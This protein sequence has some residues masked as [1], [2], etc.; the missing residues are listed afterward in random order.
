MSGPALLDLALAVEAWPAV[1]AFGASLWAY[2]LV[3]ALHIAGFAL[4]FGAILPVDLRLM[5]LARAEAVPA[6][7]V[8]LL[9]RLAASGLGLAVVSGVALWTVRASDYLANPW[10]WAKWVAVA[11]GVA[12]ALAYGRHAALASW[13]A[14]I[15]CGRWIAFA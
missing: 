14:A 5:G 12:N 4:L 3:S 6:P 7:T 15:V 8:E 11:I 10:L 2:P 9:R 13:L 1:R